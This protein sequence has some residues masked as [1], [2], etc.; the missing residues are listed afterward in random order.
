M[1]R[2]QRKRTRGFKTPPNTRYVGRGTKFGN[3]FILSDDGYI[4]CLHTI[5][6]CKDKW[7]RWSENGD[8]ETKDIV[9]LY[10]RWLNGD[11]KDRKYLPT[12]PTKEEIATLKGKNLSCFCSLDKPCHADVLL[13]LTLE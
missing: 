4:Y 11:L 8:F 5:T 7:I 3:P 13:K 2:I 1:K 10:E 6:S 12:P 9:E